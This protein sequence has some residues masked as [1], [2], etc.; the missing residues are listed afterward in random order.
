M[1][2]PVLLWALIAVI[3]LACIIY[4]IGDK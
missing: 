3:A 1:S 4:A 2:D